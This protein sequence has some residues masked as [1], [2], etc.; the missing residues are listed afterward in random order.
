MKPNIHADIS[1]KRFGGKS[2]D[3]MPIHDLIDSPKQALCDVRH[4]A[5]FHSAF[6]IFIVE[7]V[8]GSTITNSDGKVVSVRDIAEEHVLQDLGFVPTL[9]DWFTNM[10]IDEWMLS[11]SKY[12]NSK[13]K[14]IDL[15]ES[16]EA[17]AYIIKARDLVKDLVKEEGHRIETSPFPEMKLPLF[18]ME[19]DGR[20]RVID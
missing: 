12:T 19:W 11:N 14:K 20:T 1:V 18:P 17:K 6:G 7:R 8:F 16:V 10:P 9:Q 3:Y 5:I 2:T 15:D 4:R 13:E